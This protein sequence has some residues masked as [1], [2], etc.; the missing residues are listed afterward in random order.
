M[1]L[2]GVLP[3]SV[4]RMLGSS[5]QEDHGIT[6]CPAHESVGRNERADRIARA[7][8]CRAVD[9]PTQTDYFTPTLPRDILESQRLA[10]QK[11]AP[12]QR[13]LTRRQSRDWRQIQTNTYRNIDTLSKVRSSQFADR[14]PWCGDAPILQHITWTCQQRPAE[15]NSPLTTRN[16]FK[17]SWEV[18]LTQQDL[19]SQRVILDQAERAAQASGAL[20]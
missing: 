10:W 19:G 14:G 1:F 15:G 12:P 17:R 18:R 9:M 6:W 3:R 5:L 7:L 13:K 4:L 20:E 2:K 11:M 16:E 8:T